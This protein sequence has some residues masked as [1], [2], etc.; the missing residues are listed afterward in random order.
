MH[1]LSTFFLGLLDHLG[2]GGLFV[3]MTLANI[4]APVGS[5]IIL[6]AAGALVATGHLSNVWIAIAVALAA[7]LVGQSIAYAV[8]FYG[9]RPFVDRFGKYVRFHHAELER[10]EQF[11]AKYGKFA[12]F[13][14]RFVPVIRGIVGIP[15]G[16]AEMPLAPFYFWTF[17]GSLVFC[18]GLILLGN[19]LGEHAH[20]VIDNLRRYALVIFGIAVIAIAGYVFLKNRTHQ[21]RS[22]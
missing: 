14:C 11:F 22:A 10:V 9:G 4:G 15:A 6:P 1:A 21:R 17:L 2:Y 13:I 7:E 18:G 19:V 16:I 3:A 20:A 12:I 5:E 8:G